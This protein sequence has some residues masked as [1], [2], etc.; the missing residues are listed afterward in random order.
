MPNRI[1]KESIRK[2]ESIDNLTWFEEVFFYRLITTCDDYG[3]YDARL[4]ILKAELFPLKDGVTLKQ[5]SDALNKLST[6]G[7]VQ[8]YEYDQK[9]YL[10]LTAWGR[11]QQIRNKK[12]K[13]PAPDEKIND[14]KSID[15]N[16]NQSLAN[17]PVIQSE[18]ESESKY[19]Y[20]EPEE[21]FQCWN[22]HSIIEHKKLTD[23]MKTAINGALKDYA[24]DDIKKAISNYSEILSG[25]E[26]YFSY[27]WTLTDFLKRG[28]EKFMDL[29]TARGNY[30]TDKPKTNT[31]GKPNKFHNFIQS[32]DSQ[33]LDAIA[34][35]RRE[36]AYRK[37]KDGG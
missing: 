8:V 28:L 18:S 30:A 7:M 20:S 34:E 12:S 16:C 2:S 13:F 36:E 37:L 27:K 26:Y 29:E 21:I 35:K 32:D 23:K 17:V 5:I 31:P 1:I 25:D 9:P 11:H 10:Q 4:K 22:S 6:V 19:T 15:I 14:L 3:R 33:N 24:V